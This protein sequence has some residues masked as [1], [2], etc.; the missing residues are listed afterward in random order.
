[1]VISYFKIELVAIFFLF[2]I[3]EAI[4][5]LCLLVAEEKPVNS[6][7]FSILYA[8]VSY[9]L[10]KGGANDAERAHRMFFYGIIGCINTIDENGT[11]M[12]VLF[13]SDRSDH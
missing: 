3:F 8:V 13:L 11:K 10:L 1:M 7:L 6:I 5:F 4:K 9:P 2:S 12:F